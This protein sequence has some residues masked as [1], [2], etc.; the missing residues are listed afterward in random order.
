[1]ADIIRDFF[2]DTAHTQIPQIVV[3]ESLVHNKSWISHL[4]YLD[5]LVVGFVVF[6]TFVASREV[7]LF[8]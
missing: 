3:N 7:A 1:M 2:P 4:H 5:Q 8:W 6:Q